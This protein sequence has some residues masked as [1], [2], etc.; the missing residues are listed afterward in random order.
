MGGIYIIAGLAII[1]L[2]IDKV[3]GAFYDIF[4]MAFNPVSATG[5]FAGGA[6]MAK[7]ITIGTARGGLFSNEAGIG[8]SP[9]IHSSAI[10]DHP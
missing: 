8:S 2:N 1:I 4:T 9:I 3:P 6:T 7:M 5:G 10:V